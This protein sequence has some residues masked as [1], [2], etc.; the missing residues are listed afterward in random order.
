MAMP[1]ALEETAYINF[2]SS[3]DGIGLRP[4]EGLISNND[5]KKLIQKLKSKKSLFTTRK[6]N[7]KN[8]IYEANITF[9]DALKEN[10]KFD[11]DRFISAHAIVLSIEGIPA[12][13][14]NSLFGSKNYIDGV[15]M[16]NSNRTINR[17]KWNLNQIEKMINSESDQT[18]IFHS[19]KK[20]IEIR[21]KQKAFHPNAT[22]FTL[23]LGEK[24]FGIWRQSR[25]RKQSIFCITN[26]SKKIETFQSLD[27]NLILDENWYDLI[28]GDQIKKDLI[29]VNPYKTIWLSNSK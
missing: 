7:N 21:K 25:D 15:K 17:Q 16:T 29:Q 6:K 28:T 10:D 26:L 12:I 3:H 2:L 22:S 20:L 5:Y 13:Y 18:L 14:V 11:V 1:P 19:L 24:L 8:L 4:L 9:F 27:L 23:Q